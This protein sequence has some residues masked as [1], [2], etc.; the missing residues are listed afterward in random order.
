MAILQGAS[1]VALVVKNL[2]ARARGARDSGSIPEPGQ[3]PEEEIA[4]YSSILAWKI[5]W[6]EETGGLQS[7]KSER[8]RHN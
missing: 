7:M 4:L 2:P 1:Q 8:V 3:S 6:V 5:S